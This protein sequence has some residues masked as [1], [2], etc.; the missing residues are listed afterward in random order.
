[1]HHSSTDKSGKGELTRREILSSEKGT[2]LKKWGGKIPVCVVFPN[3]YHIGMSN[4]STQI[5]YKTLNDIPEI[6]CER[7][8]V[9]ENGGNLSLE[10]GRPISSF[11]IIFFTISYELDYMNIVRI[12]RST[13]IALHSKAR[14]KDEPLVVAGG[15]C[16]MS[17]PE[18]IQGFIDL[19]LMGDIEATIPDFM[20]KYMA[21][22]EKGRDE[23]LDG[24]SVFDWVYNP[25]KLKVTYMEDG[26]IERFYPEDFHVKPKGFTGKHLG[27]S[28]V[29]AENT[30]FSNMYLVEG[31]RGCPSQCP[32]CL[33][34][35][36]YTFKHDRLLP[37]ETDIEDIGI[38][39]GGVSFH[40]HLFE[41]LKELKSVG[42]HVHFPSLRIDET[43][44]PVIELIRDE[45]KTLTFGIEAGAERLRAFIG[46]PLKNG[47]LYEKI[48]S[49]L[50]IKPFN[51]KFYF[52]IGLFGE[53]PED[54]EDIVDLVKRTKH[55][56]VKHG[57]KKGFVGSITVH[58]SPF[59]PKPSTP[60]QWLPMEEMGELKNRIGWLKRAI[61]KID[62]TYFT[63]ESVKYS[64]IQGVLARGDRRMGDVIERL[65]DGEN[66]NKVLK[67][68]PVNLNFYTFR[69]RDKNELFPWDFIRGKK[70]KRKLYEILVS[71]LPCLT[72]V[73]L[74]QP[75]T[76]SNGV[77]GIKRKT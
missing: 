48:D 25:W 19:F 49:I 57:A 2:I 17:N 27:S 5:L 63:H 75:D 20:E 3:S 72:T 62:N 37:L 45:I 65:A 43:P 66:L 30:E 15:I 38:I 70:S 51:L 34:G 23:I 31:T 69:E 11:R 4:L 77:S 8:F 39:G 68:S 14:R 40:P 50:A 33:L 59:V 54:L 7:C 35:N 67:T 53:T 1:M 55:T 26:T 12:L 58:V 22:K 41:V 52:M 24:L 16:V 76:V 28:Q 61:G 74:G 56:M 10:S 60:F 6:V 21:T 32:F 44:L 64:F 73:C 46:K 36:T 71:K 9:D 29:I 47:E 42:K 18:P 13:S